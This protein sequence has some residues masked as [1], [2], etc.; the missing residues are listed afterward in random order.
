MKIFLVLFFFVLGI[1]SL[2]FVSF[3]MLWGASE[4]C[5]SLTQELFRMGLLE[6]FKT[7]LIPMGLFFMSYACHKFLK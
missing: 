6:V 7:F 5:H 3:M 1:L 4:A 2:L